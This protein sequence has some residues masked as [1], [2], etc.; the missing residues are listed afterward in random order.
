MIKILFE[1]PTSRFQIFFVYRERRYML[2]EK[3]VVHKY[4][5]ACYYYC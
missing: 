2:A 3:R 5:F 4:M 1:V